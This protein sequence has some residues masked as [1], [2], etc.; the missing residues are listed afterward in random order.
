M[1][2]ILNSSYFAKLELLMFEELGY[3]LQQKKKI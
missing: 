3:A 2:F 1:V